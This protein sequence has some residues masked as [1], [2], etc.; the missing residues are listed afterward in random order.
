[1]TKIVQLKLSKIKY[2]GDSIGRNIRVEIEVLGK[3]LRVDKRINTGITMEINQEV[4]R[5]ETDRGIFQADVFITILERDLLFNDVDNT[6]GKIKVNT[7]VT[8]SQQFVFELRVRETRSIFGK[9]LGKAI[10]IFEIMLETEA[11]DTIKYVP[12]EGDGWLQVVMEDR[13]SEESLPAYLKV[14]IDRVNN[15]REYFTILEGPYRGRPA[16]VKLRDNNY[17]RFIAEVRHE[18]MIRA[19]YSISKKIF[20]LKGKKYKT[21]DYPK[22]PWQKGLYDIEIPDYPHKGGRNYLDQSKRAMTWFKIG[23]G[24]ERYLHAGGL[25][26]GCITVIET[27]RWMEVYNI[28]IRARKDDFMSVGVLEVVD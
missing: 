13:Y 14:K 19:K 3:F 25:S 21:V 23:H 26:L 28:L 2:S 7:A 17:S 11:S 1:M 10:A 24:G 16:S 27:S 22:A 4:G 18:Y 6:K 12:D 15:K 9:F 5:F 8:K 20:I